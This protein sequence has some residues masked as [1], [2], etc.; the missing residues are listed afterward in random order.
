MKARKTY[1]FFLFFL[2]VVSNF[3]SAYGQKPI[4]GSYR[5]ADHYQP[6]YIDSGDHNDWLY[7][8]GGVLGTI[9]GFGLGHAV[10]GRWQED[11]W[12]FT[13]L[14]L[15]GLLAILLPSNAKNQSSENEK[16]IAIQASIGF[17]AVFGSRIWEIIDVWQ[18]DEHKKNS[19]VAVEL[20]F[21]PGSF[22]GSAFFGLNVDL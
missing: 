22:A 3:E 6:A 7:P 4:I 16:K 11:G 13:A 8:L 15:A 9:Y 17:V 18:Y 1:Q 5:L 19:N 21:L 2:L 20:G 12:L 10:Q 14:P